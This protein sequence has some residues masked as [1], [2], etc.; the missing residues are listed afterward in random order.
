MRK[1]YFIIFLLAL[2]GGMAVAGAVL[3]NRM[4]QAMVGV[5][6]LAAG[7]PL[8]HNMGRLKERLLNDPSL[9][10]SLD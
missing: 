9:D 8:A 7:I 10:P 3:E 4:G 2:L 6:L 1:G 5:G